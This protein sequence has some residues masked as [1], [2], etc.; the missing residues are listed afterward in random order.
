MLSSLVLLLVRSNM[1]ESEEAE[2]LEFILKE[3][4]YSLSNEFMQFLTF[5]KQETVTEKA[6]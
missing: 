6:C 1:A 2:L 5:N 3:K 4:S